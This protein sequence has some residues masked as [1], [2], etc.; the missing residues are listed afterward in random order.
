VIRKKGPRLPGTD[1]GGRLER[2]GRMRGAGLMGEGGKKH[3]V[4]PSVVKGA[5]LRTLGEEITWVTRFLY[6]AE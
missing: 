6:T 1:T 5:S 4:C 2:R 3:F